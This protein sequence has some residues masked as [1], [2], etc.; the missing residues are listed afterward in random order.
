M[1]K[2]GFDLENFSKLTEK[3]TQPVA[4]PQKPIQAAEAHP[5]F[6]AYC[7]FHMNSTNAFVTF[8]AWIFYC[9]RFKLKFHLVLCDKQYPSDSHT[10]ITQIPL[11]RQS[12]TALFIKRYSSYIEL[13]SARGLQL[14]H[15]IDANDFEHFSESQ[16]PFCL[17]LS[18]PN[19]FCST[20]ATWACEP[21]SLTCSSLPSNTSKAF[22][23]KFSIATANR[24]KCSLILDNAVHEIHGAISI[25]KCSSSVHVF[26]FSFF[27][28]AMGK[29]LRRRE[30]VNDAPYDRSINSARL[31]RS[32]LPCRWTRGFAGKLNWNWHFSTWRMSRNLPRP[33]GY[34][35]DEQTFGNSCFGTDPIS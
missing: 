19:H 30:F 27:T 25:T 1:R 24:A 29:H 9:L 31:S 20:I 21:S 23:I 17:P 34:W 18:L 6:D 28:Y 22:V 7:K 2:V 26:Q 33:L 13:Q 12:F 32:H 10:Q 4:K 8:L 11:T 14:S 35:Y 5:S 15:S 16:F 3:A